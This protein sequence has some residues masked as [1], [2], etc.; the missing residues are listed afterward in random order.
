MVFYKHVSCAV[1]LEPLELVLTRLGQECSCVGVLLLLYCLKY[2][3]YEFINESE[4]VI[5]FTLYSIVQ[6]FLLHLLQLGIVA[7]LL[8]GTIG[9]IF[10]IELVTVMIKLNKRVTYQ[11]TTDSLACLIVLLLVSSL[12]YHYWA[13]FCCCTVRRKRAV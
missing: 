2:R 5:S 12:S 3:V 10:Y 11:P 6:H 4:C 7:V 9:H 8:L 13:H 1:C